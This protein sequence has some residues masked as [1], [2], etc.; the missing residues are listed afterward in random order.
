[1]SQ[2]S[3][4]LFERDESVLS[5]DKFFHSLERLNVTAEEYFEIYNYYYYDN[6]S[7][8]QFFLDLKES[9]YKSDIKILSKMLNSL[10]IKSR[11]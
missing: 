3:L 4:S 11:C 1:M 10:K 9:Y 5:V 6:F 8:Y 2:A 7:L